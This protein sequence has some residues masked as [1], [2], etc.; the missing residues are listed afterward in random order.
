[1]PKKLHKYMVTVARATFL[2]IEAVS[3]EDAEDQAENLLA[4]PS[5]ATQT[6]ISEGAT[7]W[8]VTDCERADGEDEDEDD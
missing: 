2:T 6:L 8:E 7:E 4:D 1:M 3:R 5:E